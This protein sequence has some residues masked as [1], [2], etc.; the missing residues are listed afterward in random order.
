MGASISS[1]MVMGSPQLG[2]V[3]AVVDAAAGSLAV[4]APLL[5][6]EALSAV[7]A[8]VDALLAS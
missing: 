1:V 2:A 3:S 5:A 7:V 6:G 4:G 8:L